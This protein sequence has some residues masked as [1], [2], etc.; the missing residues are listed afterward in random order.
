MISIV[1]MMVFAASAGITKSIEAGDWTWFARSGSI[2]V[3]VSLITFGFSF[4]AST[5][6]AVSKK[7]FEHV[8]LSMSY[9]LLALLGG[10]AGTIIWG[11]G[12]LVGRWM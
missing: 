10:I 5:R 8:N 11:F 1:S 9:Y 2:I 12:D 6:V 4:T 7:T 3:V